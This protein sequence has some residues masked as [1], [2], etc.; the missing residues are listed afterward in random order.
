MSRPNIPT[1]LAAVLHGPRD[2]RIESHILPPPAP[3]ELQI[4]IRTTTLCGSDLHYYHDYRNGD[5]EIT[6]PLP[7]GH[8]SAGVVIA[9]GARAAA[10]GWRAGDR[11]ALEVG[12][13]CGAC[14]RCVDGRYNLC[15]TLRF[16]G[17]AKAVPHLWGTLQLH[18]NHPARWCHR[19]PEHV[20]LRAGALAEPLAVALHAVVRRARVAPGAT[21]MV[22]GA[23]PVGLLVAACA[24]LAGATRVLVHDADVGRVRFARAGA[25]A[26]HTTV[27]LPRALD[28][29]AERLEAARMAAATALT[30]MECP[31]GVDFVFE[32]TGAESCAQMG[33]YAA[34]AGGALVLIGMGT[35]V[36][37]LP[38]SA[39]AL[40]E[41]DIIGGFRYAN[42]YPLAIELLASGRLD[43]KKIESLVTQSFAGIDQVDQ[44]FQ[45]ASSPA[46]VDGEP[47]IKVEVCF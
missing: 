11:V 43:T 34:R 47:V 1:T 25:W 44:A 41:V 35:P 16:R 28:A 45:M 39:A 15:G 7:L 13:P 26:T 32:C 30:V 4:A 18:L 22:L 24:E 46:D 37:T 10:L 36:M 33:I 6:S 38:I 17:S 40:R 19:L 27:A 5:I 3:T 9:A 23:G 14:A 8:E 21:V 42:S 31:G 29:V 2:L 12:L 20:S